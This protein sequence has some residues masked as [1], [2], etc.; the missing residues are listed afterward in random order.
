MRYCIEMLPEKYK[1][2]VIL[3]YSVELSVSEIAVWLKIP[4][5]KES[6]KCPF[7]ETKT[8]GKH[9]ERSREGTKKISFLPLPWTI[10]IKS[11]G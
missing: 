3:Y 5:E 9:M 1:L 4:E 7:V 11:N 2:P 10:E 8:L 6:D